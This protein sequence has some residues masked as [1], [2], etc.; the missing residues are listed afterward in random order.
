MRDTQELNR[1]Y[2]KEGVKQSELR[3]GIIY[4]SLQTRDHLFFIADKGGGKYTMNLISPIHWYI[5]WYK[6]STMM[7]MKPICCSG[8][9]WISRFIRSE[10]GRPSLRSL[11][12]CSWNSCIS[13]SVHSKCSSLVFDACERS[14][15]SKG[16]YVV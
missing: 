9:F 15:T 11:S 14:A 7:F 10:I 3:G 16:Q 8:M 13:R 5:G 6:G 4:F 1:K 2:R 12:P